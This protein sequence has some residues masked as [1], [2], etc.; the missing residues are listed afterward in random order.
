VNTDTAAWL[1][2][3]REWAADPRALIFPINGERR[4]IALFPADIVGKSDD[5]LLAFIAGRLDEHEP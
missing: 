4:S 3:M 5:E 1:A 2:E